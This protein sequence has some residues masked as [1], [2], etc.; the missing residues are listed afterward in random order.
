MT[1]KTFPPVYVGGLAKCGSSKLNDMSEHRGIFLR[2]PI[3]QTIGFGVRWLID[4]KN[5]PL[6]CIAVPNL[7]VL[8]RT[9]RAYVGM[10]KYFYFQVFALFITRATHSIARSSLLQRVRLSVTRRYCV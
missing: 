10:V 3:P 7:V 6:T 9:V 1:L 8:N 2:A 4:P 5:F